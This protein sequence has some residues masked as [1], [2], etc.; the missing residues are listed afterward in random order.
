MWYFLYFYSKH[1][2]WMLVRTQ[3][4]YFTQCS[5]G[6]RGGAGEGERVLFAYMPTC[7][8]EPFKSKETH[9][10]LRQMVMS[11][12]SKYFKINWLRSYFIVK[13]KYF[14]L[15]GL[16]S[17]RQIRLSIQLNHVLSTIDKQILFFRNLWHYMVTYSCTVNSHKYSVWQF[18]YKRQLLDSKCAY[19]FL[20]CLDCSLFAIKYRAHIQV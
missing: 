20:F 18:D 6:G 15:L 13:H 14:L 10:T 8:Q 3:V 12:N 17:W 19:K 4:F 16:R 2:L 9:H 11:G 7:N 1:V 5:C